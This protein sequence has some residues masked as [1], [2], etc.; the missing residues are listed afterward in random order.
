MRPTTKNIMADNCLTLLSGNID[1][2]CHADTAAM[3]QEMLLINYSDIQSHTVAEGVATITLATGA[4]P[5]IVK[6][7]NASAGASEAAKIND[8]TPPAS[9]HTV[10]GTI[11]KRD[12][13]AYVQA[14]QIRGGRFVAITKAEQ[15]GV[16]EVWGLRAGLK[17]TGGDRNTNEDSGFF[18]FTLTT[19][20]TS[21]GDTLY[22]MTA[23]AYE[24]LKA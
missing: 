16:Y 23:E 12:A 5:S 2:D 21:N 18:T 9:T 10:F 11:F 4:T 24:A 15:S 17:L 8:K 20:E 7:F 19:P 1:F 3:L 22:S 13:E 6:V 14:E